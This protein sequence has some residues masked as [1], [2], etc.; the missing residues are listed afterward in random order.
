M[1]NIFIC[2]LL[3]SFSCSL[4]F[5]R[6]LTTINRA[7]TPCLV[8]VQAAA[9]HAASEQA[10]ETIDRALLAAAEAHQLMSDQLAH[11]QAETQ[12]LVLPHM[13]MGGWVMG[14]RVGFSVI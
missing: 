8:C 2:P 3:V 7:L 11:A 5:P 13:G 6:T 4:P 10:Q 14:D 1:I 9:V 12:Q